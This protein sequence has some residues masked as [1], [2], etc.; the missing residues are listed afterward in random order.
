MSTDCPRTFLEALF[1]GT[2]HNL[3]HDDFNWGSQPGKIGLAR[4]Q[5]TPN[6]EPKC[7]NHAQTLRDGPAGA[8]KGQGSERGSG[9]T[10]GGGMGKASAAGLELTPRCGQ[11]L[12]SSRRRLPFAHKGTGG[13]G[14]GSAVILNGP[15]ALWGTS[16]LNPDWAQV[17]KYPYWSR[18]WYRSPPHLGHPLNK[19]MIVAIIDSDFDGREPRLG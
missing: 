1:L 4:H 10:Y 8:P 6:S 14:T 16:L 18:L 19:I 2:D 15:V 13:A 12:G 5:M 17:T 9:L 7:A 11:E 3:V